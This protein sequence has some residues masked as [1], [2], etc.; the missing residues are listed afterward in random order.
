MTWVWKHFSELSVDE[1]YALLQLRAVVFVVEQDCAYL[2][3]DGVDPLCD[4]LLGYDEEG[5]C[6]SVRVVPPGLSHPEVSIGRVV[7]A[8]RV[9][10]TGLGRPLME[11]ALRH[12]AAKWPGPIAIGAQA[13]LRRYYESFGFVVC[14]PEYDEDGI[15]HLPMRRG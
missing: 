7:T 3:L 12:V 15:P 10:G 6:A 11:E 4:H 2:D 14:D 13:H 1:L 5:L 9:R 8:P